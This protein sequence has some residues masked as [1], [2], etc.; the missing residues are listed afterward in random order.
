MGEMVTSEH[1]A[2][3]VAQ[4]L[5]KGYTLN[6]RLLRPAM[7]MIAKAPEA[8]TAEEEIAETD[9]NETESNDDSATEDE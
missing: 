7:V 6:D 1:P 9:E 4:A 3:S 5:Q 8:E 2:G